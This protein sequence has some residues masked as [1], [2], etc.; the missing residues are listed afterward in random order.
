MENKF[1]RMLTFGLTCLVLIYS[2]YSV[3]DLT[4]SDKDTTVTQDFE[5]DNP[6]LEVFIWR[7][8]SGGYMYS[9][10]SIWGRNSWLCTSSTSLQYGG[11]ATSP[12]WGFIAGSTTIPI[13][14]TETKSGTK[15]T[16]NI[17][18]HMRP[19]QNYEDCSSTGSTDAQI[20]Q[21]FS[22]ASQACNGRD[23][24]ERK[25]TARILQSELKKIPFPG[26]WTAELRLKLREW[27]G[28]D[29]GDWKAN[30]TLNVKSTNDQ[31]I[32]LPQFP[33]ATPHVD[34]NLRPLPG[35]TANRTTMEGSNSIDICLYDG[36]GSNSSRVKLLLR[37]EE[38]A[39]DKRLPGRFSL[40]HEGGATDESSRVDYAVTM[41][42]LKGGGQKPVNNGDEIV[43]S[44]PDSN[45]RSFML[46]GMLHPVLCH[47]S[48]LQLKP[49]S[50]AIADKKSGRYTGKLTLIFTPET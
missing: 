26:V 38:K 8:E 23:F 9:N 17:L 40:Y 34:L 36:F 20:Q 10:Y 21:A 4:P 29:V 31:Q 18:A 37:D 24:N 32:Y 41:S 42:D 22:Q 16:I 30:I 11:C 28:T 19:H 46:P 7:S 49:L 14:L 47:P 15:I 27:P 44:A 43:W 35:S 33:I 45:V 48:T 6:P 12:V 1:K 3:A 39:S 50:F 5:M 2:G 25:L 13:T